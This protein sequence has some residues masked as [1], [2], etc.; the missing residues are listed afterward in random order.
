MVAAPWRQRLSAQEST[1]AASAAAEDH[2]IA[3]PAYT[4]G[5]AGPRSWPMNGL[6]MA[7]AV[8][9]VKGLHE[10]AR[11][12]KQRLHGAASLATAATR[13]RGRPAA[14]AASLRLAAAHCR[15]PRES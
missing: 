14:A 15:K 2:V 6:S 3:P 7:A 1:H 11:I 9:D 10:S 13:A 4:A 8:G 12:M 5:L